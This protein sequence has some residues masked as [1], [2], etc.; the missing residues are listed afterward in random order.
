MEE[1]VKQAIVCFG[2][3][4]YREHRCANAFKEAQNLFLNKEKVQQVLN[5]TARYDWKKAVKEAVS[6]YKCYFEGK[7]VYEHCLEQIASYQNIEVF[8]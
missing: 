8:V 7:D 3:G 6:W 2:F 5:W 1:V 4:S